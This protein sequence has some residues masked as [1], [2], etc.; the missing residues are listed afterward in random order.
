M[1]RTAAEGWNYVLY[2]G[3]LGSE[4]AKRDTIRSLRKQ[5]RMCKELRYGFYALAVMAAFFWIWY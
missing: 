5:V 3:R 2:S 1:A 4:E